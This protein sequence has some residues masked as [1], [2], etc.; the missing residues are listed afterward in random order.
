MPNKPLQSTSLTSPGFFGLNTQDSGVDMSPNYALIARNA[1][2]DR[3]GRIGARKGWQ[4]RT[5]S[6][7]T[8]SNPQ[9]VAEFDN[10]DGTFSILSFGNNK[11]FV[12]ET[13]MTEKFVRNSNNSAN[14]VTSLLYIISCLLVAA[15]LMHTTVTMA[16]NS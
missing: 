2:I 8:S 15:L 13:T 16:F 1:V 11:L 9:V 14:L 6:G 7:G 4:Y 12:G 10:H 5:S 3:F